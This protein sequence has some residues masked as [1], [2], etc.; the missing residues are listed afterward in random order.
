MLN[1]LMPVAGR[2]SRVNQGVFKPL[3][4]IDGEPLFIRALRCYIPHSDWRVLV[5]TRH[6]YGQVIEEHLIEHFTCAWEMAE[7]P[8]VLPGMTCSCM[9]F[10]HRLWGNELLI[11]VGDH[12]I[13]W[14]VNEFLRQAR[15]HQAMVVTTK[16]KADLTKSYIVADRFG[17]I[18]GV[19]IKEP[20]SSD[21]AIFGAFYFRDGWD[22]WRWGMQTMVEGD[23]YHGECYVDSIFNHTGQA[24]VALYDVPRDKITFLGTDEEIVAW[25]CARE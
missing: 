16:Q 12:L 21:D 8:D 17:G 13:D 3:L 14:D 15:L 1:I 2:G 22:F 24:D 18:C 11:V 23:D 5:V 4:D 9:S 10:G 6:P 20:S 19:H 7:V 25:R